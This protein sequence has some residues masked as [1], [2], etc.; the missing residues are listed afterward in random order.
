MHKLMDSA[1]PP[2]PRRGR[3]PAAARLLAAM[4]VACAPV[5]AGEDDEVVVVELEELEVGQLEILDGTLVKKTPD[6]DRTAAREA[7][8]IDPSKHPALTALLDGSI[9]KQ[10]AKL[11]ADAFKA[12]E[13]ATR[14]LI[15]LGR[16]EDREGPEKYLAR[17]RVLEHMKKLKAAKDPE[18]GM[19]ARRVIKTLDPPPKAETADPADPFEIF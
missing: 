13:R 12:R 7:R 19:R 10:A 17:Q 5:F 18:V 14:E 8:K 2:R 9:A 16:A 15:K 11:G 6:S 4:L 3:R 1:Q